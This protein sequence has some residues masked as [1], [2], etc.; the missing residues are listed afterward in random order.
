MAF[1]FPPLEKAREQ[2]VDIYIESFYLYSIVHY[3]MKFNEHSMITREV[4]PIAQ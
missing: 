4:A 1:F 3:V 2:R